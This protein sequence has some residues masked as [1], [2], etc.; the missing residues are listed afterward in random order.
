MLL[1]TSVWLDIA[2]DHR[3]RHIVHG[4]ETLNGIGLELLVPQLVVDEF[5]RNKDRLIKENAQSLLSALRRARDVAQRFGSKRR[6]VTVLSELDELERG[7]TDFGDQVADLISRIE[8]LLL[9]AKVIET[10]EA[11]KLH[12]VERA[13]EKKAPFHRARN[14]MADAVI[15]EVFAEAVASG[16]AKDNF[17]FVTHNTKDFSSIDGDNRVAHPDFA[18]V[19]AN[20]RSRF[21]I[22]IVDAL[23]A[24][25]EKD[26][27]DLTRE[28]QLVEA[29]PR[30]LK[31]I[32][33]VEEELTLKRWYD[34]HQ[35]R[36]AAIKAGKTKLVDKEDFSEPPPRGG[37]PI[38]KEI[39]KG[40]IKAAKEVERR[41]GKRNLGP[42][43]DF[44]WGML[45]GKQSAIRWVLGYEWDNLD[46]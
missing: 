8:K 33:A 10:S 4:I 9:G 31:E 21:F 12:A 25:F 27:A 20:S 29:P 2:G 41:F 17:A 28:S 1:D 13:L 36:A 14:S 7:L 45:A 24:Y 39:W 16:A 37:R 43:T 30:S 38:E 19:F 15:F 23:K 11:A 32:Q 26:V 22:S 35:M 5:L 42:Y 44:E 46:T 6:K 3:S 40:A 34:H 18:P